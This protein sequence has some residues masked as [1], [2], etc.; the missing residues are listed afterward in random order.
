MKII[1]RI[2]IILSLIFGCIGIMFS[3]SAIV[4][5]EEIIDSSAVIITCQVVAESTLVQS[6]IDSVSTPGVY[7]LNVEHDADI[8]FVKM[9]R[10]LKG[11]QSDSLLKVIVLQN[12]SSQ[13]SNQLSPLFISGHY[14]LYLN[15]KI[16]TGSLLQ[17]YQITEN[18][19]FALNN[20]GNSSFELNDTL[21]STTLAATELYLNILSIPWQVKGIGQY[22][23]SLGILTQ[24]EVLSGGITDS[25]FGNELRN[26]LQ[27]AS[28]LLDLGDSTST[29]RELIAYVIK[30][31]N[32]FAGNNP[33][34]SV[35]FKVYS[36]LYNIA[37]YILSRL[38]N[39]PPNYIIEL[40]GSEHG[41][42]IKN[43]NQTT[44]DQGSTIQLVAS[45]S[46]G[47]DFV[48]WSGDAS[49]S[50][51]PLTITV[52]D[53]KVVTA[54]FSLQIHTIAATA[55]PNG[56]LTP[57]GIVNVN[58]GSSQAYTITP[59][60]CYRI[61][62]VVVNGTY[63]G[64]MS[65]Y[66]FNNVRGDSTI[67]AVFKLN[68]YTITPTA[69]SNGSISPSTPTTVNCGSNQ[70]I[71]I[72]PNP[73]Y[74]I[75]SVI[76]NGTYRGTMSSYT[77]NNIRGDST[78]RVVFKLNTYTVTPTAGPNGS[79]S[80]A[81]P[82]SVNCGSNQ[83]FTITPSTNYNTDSVIVNG[84]YKGT[85][86]SY[87]FNNVRGDS[88]IR[89]VFK[90]KTYTLTPTVTNGGTIS[91]SIPITLNYGASQR[92][93]F[94]YNPGYRV[95][96]VKVDGVKVDSTIGYTFSNVADNHTISVKFKRTYN[97]TVLTSPSGRIDSADGIAYTN[98]QTFT[99]DSAST[100]RIATKS[101]QSL[102]TGIQY[103]FSNW[104]DN[105]AI[106]HTVTA[107]S[108]VT[109]IA[110]FNVS[111]TDSVSLNWNMLSVPAVV[112]NFSSTSVYPA[113]T[114][115]VY[116]YAPA[117]YIAKDTLKNGPGYWVKVGGNTSTVNYSGGSVDSVFVNV[118]LGWN[119]I[120]SVSYPIV[121]SNIRNDSII[122]SSMFEYKS[123]GYVA[124]DTLKPG[125]G[126]WIK[127]KQ[128]GQLVLGKIDSAVSAITPVQPPPPPGA[129]LAPVLYL[130]INDAKNQSVTPPLFWYGSEGATSY[131]LQVSTSSSFSSL[132]YDNASITTTS[133]QIGGL[134]YSTIYYWKVNASNQFGASNWSGIRWFTTQAPPPPCE[135]CLSST[136]SLDA[137]T[138]TDA[139]GN[140]QQL[141]VRN[142]N[143]P[144]KLGF[145]DV[146][147]PP[148]PIAG[149]FH[150]RFASSKFIETAPVKKSTQLKIAV[151]DAK[152][153][154][155]L[156]W[157][158]LPENNTK[159]WLIRSGQPKV[160]LTG[161]GNMDVM[162]TSSGTII[163]TTQ[164]EPPPCEQ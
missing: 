92:F 26:H 22:I 89:A 33:E 77:F 48:G 64:T 132:T 108:N 69:G 149:L 49:G 123:S 130:P 31:E 95:D 5:L 111:I 15:S 39:L 76:V 103:T 121:K 45:P 100:H 137:F 114:N 20:L 53:N 6:S 30:I 27:I 134:A 14:I 83:T 104:T 43:P 18:D 52:D 163:I 67:R 28:D 68:T 9:H 110:R 34:K 161:I 19:F 17:K 164:A 47:Y 145:T 73:C 74:R 72:A 51:N 56:S 4:N 158:V 7:K 86:S 128:A 140:S 113:A 70:T 87:T 112:N 75:D 3:Q 40:I 93:T 78:I 129:P 88:A 102:G 36:S 12:D 63:R 96:T 21:G 55:G 99:W 154:V 120:G 84:T 142:G 153:V 59:N 160:A 57:S 106:G 62:S 126:Y 29:A 162:T 41:Q 94:T 16:L 143:R 44:Y 25:T 50:S 122:I 150:A 23:D 79:I 42:I 124:S 1:L 46:G 37:Q 138:F 135:C 66:T 91:P 141:F 71:T 125:K 151:N 32:A 81:T 117:G 115:P 82:T 58:Y 35:D 118:D 107:T 97:I 157:N 155:K 147:M 146:E 133:Q 148:K 131:R 10:I 2:C 101:P 109:Y 136:T 152:G 116:A 139:A 98:V 105:G 61:D 144:L 60:A 119:L 85:V 159:Y 24:Q 11:S 127:T 54:T 156:S 65:S 38:P 80:P 90:I 8:L 13:G